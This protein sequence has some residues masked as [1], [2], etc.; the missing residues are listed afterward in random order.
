MTQW[1]RKGQGKAN[2]HE[3]VTKVNKDGKITITFDEARGTWKALRDYGPWFDSAI[4]I[5]TKD[6]CEPYHNS[7]KDISTTHK[8]DIQDRMLVS[9]NIYSYKFLIKLNIIKSLTVYVLT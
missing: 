4:D 8:R 3:I 9:K 6:I 5:H 7:W 1:R 2:G